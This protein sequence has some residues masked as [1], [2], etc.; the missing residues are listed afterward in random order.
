MK[1]TRDQILER[2]LDLLR[3]VARDWD[4]AG[5]LTGETRLF[6][7]LAFESLDLVVLGASVQEHFG[8]RFPF[9]EFF[10][11]IGQRAVRDLTV[12]EWVEFIEQH[13]Q[14]TPVGQASRIGETIVESV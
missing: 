12:L 10:A 1:P 5:Q 13:L 7:D 11:D 3:G 8:Q 6:A 2:V 14:D 9:S 4:F